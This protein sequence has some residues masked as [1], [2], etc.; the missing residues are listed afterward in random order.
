VQLEL[1]NR[2]LCDGKIRK[3]RTADTGLIASATRNEEVD[4]YLKGAKEF[5]VTGTLKIWKRWDDL[6]RIKV[7]T[8]ILA[9]PTTTRYLPRGLQM[10][11]ESMP[12]A[13]A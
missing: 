11:T 5:N 6:P 8:L 4:N 1:I 2:F 13:S 12:N 7:R 3:A 9:P 10:M